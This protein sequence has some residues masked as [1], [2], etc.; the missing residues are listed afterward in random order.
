MV[1][2]TSSTNKAKPKQK[3]S[4]KCI[5]E[6][7]VDTD[8]E[9]PFLTVTKKGKKRSGILTKPEETDIVTTVRFP[10]ELLD[11]RH[12]KSSDKAFNKLNFA[13]LCAGEL[14]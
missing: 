2:N 8:D 1:V 9:G 10:H 6:G 12:I 14:E 4:V 5:Q 7:E 11:E 3:V 13:Q